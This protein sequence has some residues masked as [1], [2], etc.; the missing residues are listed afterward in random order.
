MDQVQHRRPLVSITL[1]FLSSGLF[2]VSVPFLIFYTQPPGS[3]A[4]TMLSPLE[5]LVFFFGGWSSS[6]SETGFSEDAVKHAPSR[7]KAQG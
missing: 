6:R 3:P 4:V 7:A 1:H 5:D 2:S